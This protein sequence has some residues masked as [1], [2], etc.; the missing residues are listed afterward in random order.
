MN[1]NLA[2][3]EAWPFLLI[4]AP[5]IIGLIAGAVMSKKHKKVVLAFAVGITVILSGGVAIAYNTANDRL[6][7]QSVA[8]A[9]N[10]TYG[11]HIGEAE[12][13]KLIN[14][15][16]NSRY[17]DGT[18]F[19]RDSLNTSSANYTSYGVYGTD[20]S[21]LGANGKDII[22]VNMIRRGSNVFLAKYDLSYSE[23]N[24]NKLNIGDVEL[25]K[26]K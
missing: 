4:L 24:G 25:P 7:A 10:S 22:S 17:G 19:T 14:G 16:S 11:L 5:A 2:P 3:A 26:A 18:T 23:E 6:L 20:V 21:I 8:S 13:Q 15:A 9:V 1:I 12:A